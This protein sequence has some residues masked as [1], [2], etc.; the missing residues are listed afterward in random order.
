MW[1]RL[2]ARTPSTSIGGVDASTTTY[3]DR[4][5]HWLFHLWIAMSPE[6]FDVSFTFSSGGTT[7]NTHHSAWIIYKEAETQMLFIQ[8]IYVSD[9]WKVYASTLSERR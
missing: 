3:N 9:E 8:R 7:I 6:T 4:Y 1:R 5:N 2:L